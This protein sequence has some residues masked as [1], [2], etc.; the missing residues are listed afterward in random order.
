MRITKKKNKYYM[1][2]PRSFI[3]LKVWIEQ[4]TEHTGNECVLCSDY[5]MFKGFKCGN[6]RC[7]NIM[8]TQCMKG[9]FRS[10]N[11]GNFKCPSCQNQVDI[12]NI[13]GISQYVQLLNHPN[14]AIKIINDLK[15]AA[16]ARLTSNNNMSSS[17]SESE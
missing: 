2:G 4:K 5:V 9:Y 11:N 6:Q 14:N 7:P 1:I 10:I 15:N 8:H 3:D 13:D 16:R 12:D 17:E